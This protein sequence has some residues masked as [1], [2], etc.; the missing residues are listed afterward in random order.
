MAGQLIRAP[1]ARNAPDA[2]FTLIELL[3]VITILSVLSV[4]GAML[5]TSRGGKTAADASDLAAFRAAHTRLRSLAVHGQSLRGMYVTP[6]GRRLAERRAGRWRPT[7]PELRW[8]NPMRFDPARRAGFADPGL[9]EGPG[10]P[11]ILYYPDGRSTAFEA[12]FGTGR[13]QIRCRSDG[14]TDLR[15]APL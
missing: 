11:Q 5:A 7:G 1:A 4:G 3:V 6:Q 2:G 9:P 15:C 10:A 14:W 8:R 13:D 12:R